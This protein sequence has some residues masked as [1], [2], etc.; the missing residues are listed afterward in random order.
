[1]PC[2]AFL[3]SSVR[4][5]SSVDKRPLVGRSLLYGKEATKNNNDAHTSKC[6][7]GDDDDHEDRSDGHDSK[8]H[9]ARRVGILLV[10][11]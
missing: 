7:N 6:G 8:F 10:V 3:L 2:F 1:M 11:V 9:W 5:V 4:L